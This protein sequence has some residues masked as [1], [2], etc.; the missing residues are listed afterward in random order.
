[1][2]RGELQRHASATLVTHQPRLVLAAVPCVRVGLGLD[3]SELRVQLLPDASLLP[4][5]SNH[6]RRAL[7]LLLGDQR[8]DLA[9][10]ADQVERIRVTSRG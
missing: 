7:E 5:L 4:E 2:H 6:L 8:T 3:L 1:M 9:V 10:Q